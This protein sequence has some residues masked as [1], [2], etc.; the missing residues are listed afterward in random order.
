MHDR[1]K[2]DPELLERL[3]LI[4]GYIFD[5][6][7]TLVLGDKRNKGLNPLPGALE[8]TR[9]LAKKEIPYLLFTNGTT[10]TPHHYAKTLRECGF[11]LRDQQLMTPA[12]SAADLFVR[13]GYRRVMVLGGD[14]LGE[15]LRDVG[16]EVV[17]PN[18]SS[19]VD[20][21]LVGW[22]PDFNLSSI[23]AACNAV[24]NHGAEVF[25]A[26][27]VVFFATANGRA[28]G[29]SRA[30][31]A[32][33]RDLT[34]CRINLVGKPSIHAVGSAGRRL[35]VKTRD[36]AVVGDDPEL[37]VPMA[38]RGRG[39]AIA[40][41]T[42]LADASAYGHLPKSRQPHLIVRGVDELLELLTVV[43]GK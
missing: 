40:V 39:C 28:L 6:D 31:S 15:P 21:V 10:R 5:M 38:H 20:A 33:L 18:G 34:G 12:S 24:W 36:V 25:S 35:K 13:R 37:E 41:N 9:W 29:T 8:I 1:L 3:R 26:S 7:G 27:Q 2:A 19:D 42:G 32:M 43:Y 11:D 14:G 23:E 17:Q 16:I 30:I 22:Y 4:R